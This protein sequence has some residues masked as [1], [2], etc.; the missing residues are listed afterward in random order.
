MNEIT[1]NPAIPQLFGY[2]SFEVRALMID[3]E[4]WFVANDVCRAL[5]IQNSRNAVS[6]LDA[7]ECKMYLLDT[8]S[9]GRQST[10]L[11]NESGLYE[12]IWKSRKHEAKKFKTWLKKEVLPS[13]RKTGSYSI[14]PQ[15]PLPQPPQQRFLPTTLP[16]LPDWVSEQSAFIFRAAAS[17]GLLLLTE[18]DSLIGANKGQFRFQDSGECVPPRPTAPNE[19]QL[20]FH[21]PWMGFIAAWW[22]GFQDETGIAVTDKTIA[23]SLIVLAQLAKFFD[24]P[25]G[26]KKSRFGNKTVMKRVLDS[27]AGGPAFKIDMGDGPMLRVRV[28]KAVV[29]NWKEL[30]RLTMIWRK[31]GT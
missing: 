30:Y 14:I 29:G 1:Q 18:M 17:N 8:P 12:L 5:E 19:S 7:D 26:S 16:E 10:N 13:I 22:H 25:H 3:N 27:L 4:P 20:E 9:S 15:P 6:E 21:P 2:Q 11:I 23:T 31:F 28:D 24:F